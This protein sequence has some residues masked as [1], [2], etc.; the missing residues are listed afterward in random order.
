MR[1][2]WV[3]IRLRPHPCD[4]AV[5]LWQ[6]PHQNFVKLHKVK[7]AFFG[8]QIGPAELRFWLFK[9]GQYAMVPAG[10]KALLCGPGFLES[11][12]PPVQGGVRLHRFW[13][14]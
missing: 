12:L 4:W 3:E 8:I 14:L 13:S 9:P 7:T 2:G 11:H 1:I 6:W 10:E 5:E